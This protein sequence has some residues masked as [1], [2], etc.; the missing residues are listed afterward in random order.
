MSQRNRSTVKRCAAIAW[1]CCGIVATDALAD[2]LVLN[3]VQGGA[4]AGVRRYRE[5]DGAY[6]G[7]AGSGSTE[8]T[9]SIALGPDGNLYI[10]GNN[11]GRGEIRKYNPVTGMYLGDFVPSGSA[12]YQVPFGLTFDNGYAYTTSRNFIMGNAGVLRFDAGSGAFAG[13]IIGPNDHGLNDPTRVFTAPNGDLL[14]SDGA[15]INRYNRFKYA[16]IST[17]AEVG[18]GVSRFGAGTFGPDGNFYVTDINNN[19][20]ARYNGATGAFLDAFI[21][22]GAVTQPRGLTF[23]NDG[24]VYV[25]AGGPNGVG[26]YRYSAAGAFIGPLVTSGLPG[27][28]QIIT[29][30]NV[31]EPAATL[32]LVGATCVLRRP[33]RSR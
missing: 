27:P 1:I 11:I 10:V 3:Y 31:P 24:N 4:T 30:P 32:G 13:T 5:S 21:P 17:F 15:R 16:F 25:T 19:Q 29:A 22:S 12:G 14:V 7:L 33:R 8:E 18:N 20:V 23:G 28:G 2:V 26:I 9:N 6:L